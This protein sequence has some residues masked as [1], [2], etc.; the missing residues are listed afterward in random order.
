MM[1]YVFI[2]TRSRRRHSAGGSTRDSICLYSL[3]RGWNAVL[4]KLSDEG[5]RLWAVSGG[6]TSSDRS[7]WVWTTRT[8][9]WPRGRSRASWRRSGA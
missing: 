4:W 5:T 7:A 6:G 9:W 1:Q 2:R 8:P 3:E